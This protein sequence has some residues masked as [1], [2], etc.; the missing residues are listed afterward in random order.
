MQSTNSSISS[1]FCP[2]TLRLPYRLP[3]CNTSMS[4][5]RRHSRHA[6]KPLNTSTPWRSHTT[7]WQRYIMHIIAA[8][9]NLIEAVAEATIAISKQDD[10]AEAY[11]LRAAI[12][13]KMGQYAEAETDADKVLTIMSDNDEALT[14]KAQC[15]IATG[16]ADEA[17]QTYR[18]IIGINP[19]HADAY[20]SLGQLLM[21]QGRTEEATRLAEEALQNVPEQ[22]EGI[23]GNFSNKE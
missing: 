17:E 5:T 19:F 12:L 21:Q 20:I 4:S 15:C 9:G 16:R 1:V 14:I 22:M 18:Q 23:S 13:A 10:F 8:H 11:L 2:T 3:N 7:S 6:M